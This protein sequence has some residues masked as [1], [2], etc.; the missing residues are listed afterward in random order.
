MTIWAGQKSA[1]P[2]KKGGRT[3]LRRFRWH[4][5]QRNP[6]PAL[7]LEKGEATEHV[8]FDRG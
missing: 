6:H 1:S 7:S 4:S 8:P 5:K 3:K 2:L